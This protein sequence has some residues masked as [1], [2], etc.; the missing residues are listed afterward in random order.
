MVSTAD[1]EFVTLVQEGAMFLPN[2]LE[3][4]PLWVSAPDRD[5]CELRYELPAKPDPTVYFE[6]ATARCHTLEDDR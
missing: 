6:T 1:G 3:H 5:R 4:T 2:V